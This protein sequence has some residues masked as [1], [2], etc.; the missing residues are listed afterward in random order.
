M[1]PNARHDVTVPTTLHK[2][3]GPRRVRMT[4][5]T[6]ADLDGIENRAATA[7]VA[8]WEPLIIS[9]CNPEIGR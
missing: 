4:G 8:P 2:E 1:I 3:L 9:E 5:P 7:S 6:D